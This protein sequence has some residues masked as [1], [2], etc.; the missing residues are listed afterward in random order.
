[1]TSRS[2]EEWVR[3]GLKAIGHTIAATLAVVEQTGNQRAYAN[4]LKQVID[5]SK[6][7]GDHYAVKFA[8]AE[9]AA[10][11][12]ERPAKLNETIDALKGQRLTWGRFK[13]GV[14]LWEK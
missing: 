14:D 1:M 9:M 2:G 6:K 5:Y 3:D 11:A 7:L 13:P 10:E 8:A 12:E 4:S